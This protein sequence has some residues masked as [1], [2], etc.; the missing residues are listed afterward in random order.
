MVPQVP[1]QAEE[2]NV[3]QGEDMNQT[4]DS[5]APQ[6]ELPK[7]AAPQQ[8][9]INPYFPYTYPQWPC[10]YCAPRCPCCGRP[11]HQQG[12]YYQPIGV[13]TGTRAF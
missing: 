10:P 12:G 2:A 5:T 7:T 13:F 11:Y 1:A 6:Q 3:K 9:W 4:S 8:T